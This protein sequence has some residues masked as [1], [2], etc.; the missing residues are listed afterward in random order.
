MIDRIDTGVYSSL[1]GYK[2]SEVEKPLQTE[3]LNM[4]IE[5]P[6]EKKRTYEKRVGGFGS[7]S[8][9]IAKVSEHRFGDL[10]RQRSQQ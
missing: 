7:A 3:K 8:K 2:F 4:N 1:K 9:S 6:T 10:F 5:V